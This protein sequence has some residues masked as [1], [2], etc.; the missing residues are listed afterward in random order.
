MKADYIK[1]TN[2]LFLSL[3]I[4]ALMGYGWG[5]TAGLSFIKSHAVVLGE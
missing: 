3:L 1:F 2:Y 4:V 5:Y